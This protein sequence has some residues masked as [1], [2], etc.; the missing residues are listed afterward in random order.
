MNT[1]FELRAENWVSAFEMDG[2]HTFSV[3]YLHLPSVESFN[4]LMDIVDTHTVWRQFEG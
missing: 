4:K 2:R 1:Q 3:H